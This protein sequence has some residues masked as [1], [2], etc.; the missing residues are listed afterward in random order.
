MSLVHCMEHGRR[1]AALVLGVGLVLA[2]C[3]GHA[4]EPTPESDAPA[5]QR[6]AAAESDAERADGEGPDRGEGEAELEQAVDALSERFR[7]AMEREGRAGALVEEAGQLVQRAPDHWRARMLLG[8]MHLAN[9]SHEQALEHLKRATELEPEDAEVHVL[10]GTVALELDDVEEAQARYRRAVAIEPSEGRYRMHL[11]H[12]YMREGR[13]D[14]ARNQLLVALRHDSSMHKAH[15]ALA[16]LYGQQ[17]KITP[18][19]NHIR[20]ALDL[21]PPYERLDRDERR[22]QLTYV[23]RRAMLLRRDFQPADAL[24]VLRDLP[25]EQ[26]FDKGVMEDMA[27][28]WAMLGEEHEAAAHYEHALDRDPHDDDLAASAAH[29][30]LRA[31]EADDARRMIDRLRRINPRHGQLAALRE[32]LSEL[33]E[34]GEATFDEAAADTPSP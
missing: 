16:D 12:V 33:R 24:S 20:R 6:S 21:L 28:C 34:Q 11:A 8:Q 3:D 23:R 18:A 7:D 31:G 25:A 5:T 2:G 1:V 10:T 17:N 22:Q 27:R 32:Q 13:Y 14:E 9:E 30:Y 19:L 15:A 29:W 4:E 26:Q